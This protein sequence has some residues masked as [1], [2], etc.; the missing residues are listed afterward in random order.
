MLRGFL[1][2]RAAAPAAAAAAPGTAAALVLAARGGFQFYSPKADVPLDKFTFN[3]EFA[4]FRNK[5]GRAP[6]NN[7]ERYRKMYFRFDE[8]ARR[9]E[10]FVQSQGYFYLPGLDYV[11][12]RGCQPLFSSEQLRLHYGRHHR[13]Y[14][15][16]LNDLLPGTKF[17]GLTLDEIIRRSADDAQYSAI[18]NNAAQ[19]F[20]HMFFW[21]S[22]APWGVNMPP[23][24]KLALESQ[25]GTIETLEKTITDRA[26]AFFG[27]GWLWLV[28]DVPTARIEIVTTVNAG[29]PLTMQ[30]KVPLLAMDLWEHTWYSDY[31]NNKA[32]YVANF[33]K[34]ADW[35]WAE[36][37]WKRAQGKDYQEMYWN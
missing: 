2:P 23:D 13:A 35:H 27:S 11:L 26:M 7:V 15:N 36:R 16:K 12:Y 25:F 33:L 37:H 19:H 9:Q 34:C 8:L 29:T 20:N 17:F 3:G 22:I 10:R 6:D 5:T 21:K 4:N 31:E 24:L 1:L 30:G 14:V 18:F 28:Y 32:G